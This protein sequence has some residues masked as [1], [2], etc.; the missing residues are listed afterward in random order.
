MERF[1]VHEPVDGT[2]VVVCQ[3][4]LLDHLD[5]R[6]VMPLVAPQLAPVPAGRLNP[7]IEVDGETFFAFPQWSSGMPVGSLGPKVGNVDDQGL[8][9]LNAFDFL[10]S[11]I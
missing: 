2:L 3:S 11:G 1:D 9:I 6:F 7:R 4:P 5:V 10:I 8:A